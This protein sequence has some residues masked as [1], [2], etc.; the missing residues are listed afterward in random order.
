MI[1][2]ATIAGSPMFAFV[3]MSGFGLVRGLAVLAGARLTTPA[4]VFAFHRRF[5]SL[6]PSTR[7][8]MLAIEGI[9]ATALAVSVAGPIMLVPAAVV[10]MN[11]PGL[12]LR[13]APVRTSAS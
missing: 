13:P 9:V 10:A 1:V 2:F 7:G 5:D 11:I 3:L 8:V 6:G 12:R 4:S